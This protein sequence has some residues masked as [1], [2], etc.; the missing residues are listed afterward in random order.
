MALLF[1]WGERSAH[2]WDRMFKS[3]RSELRDEL[4]VYQHLLSKQGLAWEVAVALSANK[5]R[6]PFR[7]SR[8]SHQLIIFGRVHLNKELTS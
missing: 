7:F 3:E 8:F 6:V 1:D 5:Q 2:R 4:R